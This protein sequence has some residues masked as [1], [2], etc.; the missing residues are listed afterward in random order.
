M[1]INETCHHVVVFKLTDTTKTVGKFRTTLGMFR[2]YK[3]TAQYAVQKPFSRFLGKKKY[4][5]RK[6]ASDKRLLY[7]VQI[8]YQCS[9]NNMRIL[10]S[11]MT[12]HVEMNSNIV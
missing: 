8:A 3:C 6:C 2:A 9:V 11:Y 10:C 4:G 7:E 12:Q 5:I 1:G